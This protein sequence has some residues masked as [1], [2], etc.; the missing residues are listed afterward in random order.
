MPDRNQVRRNLEI[1]FERDADAEAK[2]RLSR[3]KCPEHGPFTGT[4]SFR[5]EGRKGRFSID[6]ACCEKATAEMVEILKRD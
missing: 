6:G 3:Y 2:K 1:E 5:M 4:V